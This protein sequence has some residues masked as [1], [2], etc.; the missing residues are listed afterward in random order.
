MNYNY[1][2]H[3]RRILEVLAQHPSLTRTSLRSKAYQR[4]PKAVSD[5]WLEDMVQKGLLERRFKQ[6]EGGHGRVG[7]HYQLTA[8]GKKKAAG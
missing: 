7:L 2:Y 6:P 4:V 5:G 8:K 1:E 3:H